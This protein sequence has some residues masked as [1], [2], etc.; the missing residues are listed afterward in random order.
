VKSRS[1]LASPP[2]TPTG[3]EIVEKLAQAFAF[4]FDELQILNLLGKEK[5]LL[6]KIFI[7]RCELRITSLNGFARRQRFIAPSIL[8]D[9]GDAT[10]G[11]GDR[12]L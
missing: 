8:E 4:F 3:F 10:N 6:L 2:I 11:T 7:F 5:H 1:G 12:F 9:A